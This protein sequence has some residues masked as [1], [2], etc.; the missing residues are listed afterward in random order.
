MS[1]VGR[2]WLAALSS[3]FLAASGGQLLAGPSA[4]VAA[5]HATASG[6]AAPAH[7]RRPAYLALGD[8]VVFGYRTGDGNAYANAANFVGYP[9]YAGRWLHLHT[10]NA[11][12]PGEATGGYL[13]ATDPDDNGCRAYKAAH[14]LHVSYPGTQA[15]F[16]QTFLQSHP[17]TSLV[18]LMLGANDGFRLESSCNG[19]I[20][21]V[22]SG[23]PGLLTQI[24]TN[25]ATAVSQL[26][27]TGYTGQIMIVDYYS[28][29]YTNAGQ[30]LLSQTLD[31]GLSSFATAHDLPLADV[32]GAMK[33]AASAAGGNTCAAGLLNVNPQDPTSCD[34]HPSQSGARVIAHTVVSTYRA[35]RQTH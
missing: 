33:Q 11:G 24:S 10:V 27:A 21:C 26:R 17:G 16:A 20:G 4:A 7:A 34:V 15:A 31:S 35:W 14:P 23:L 5:V 13:S 32:F 8:S 18:T 29:D 19:D 1:F 22:V 6:Q 25:L 30:T 2:R 9:S 28:T 12:C 3:V